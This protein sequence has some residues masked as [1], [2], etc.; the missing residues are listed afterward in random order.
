ML[1]LPTHPS[2]GCQATVVCVVLVL[3]SNG[4]ADRAMDDQS[5]HTGANALQRVGEVCLVEN[6]KP[7]ET[8]NSDCRHR[9]M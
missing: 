8:G 1:V 5:A 7:P 4:H 9:K 6:G 2:P 3:F